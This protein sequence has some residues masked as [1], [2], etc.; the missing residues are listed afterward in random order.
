MSLIK[1]NRYIRYS[2]F[3]I[4]LFWLI[5]SIKV[6]LNNFS[7]DKNINETIHQTKDYESKTEFEKKFYKNYLSWDYSNFF[8]SHENDILFSWEV[9]IKLI[10]NNELSWNISD[11]VEQIQKKDDIM[12]ISDPKESWKY[13]INSKLEKI[14]Y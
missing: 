6:Y 7:I 12:D 5:A 11:N 13:F 2:L 10:D 9:I 1:Y 4:T 14:K 8:M 3:F